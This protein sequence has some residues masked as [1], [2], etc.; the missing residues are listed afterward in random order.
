L[1]PTTCA[2]GHCT[3]PRGETCSDAPLLVRPP[4]GVLGVSALLRGVNDDVDVGPG[5]FDIGMS[6]AD[7]VFRIEL[8]AGER[9]DASLD[10][11]ERGVHSIYL[12]RSCDASECLA[13]GIGYREFFW[14]SR[15]VRFPAELTYT[16]SSAETV[17][18]VV[19]MLAGEDVD[20][21]AWR[22]LTVTWSRGSS[23][24][25]SCGGAS[26]PCPIGTTCL[27]PDDCL[28]GRCGGE[29]AACVPACSCRGVDPWCD[30]CHVATC[31]DGLQNGDETAVDTG[32]YCLGAALDTC[33]RAW[34]LPEPWRAFD[35]S[36]GYPVRAAGDLAP[37]RDDFA[38]SCGAGG[39]DHAWLVPNLCGTRITVTGSDPASPI[40][41]AVT[42]AC[43]GP[44]VACA[45]GIG[46]ATL[47]VDTAET[48]S[49]LWVD[50]PA[51]Q[52]YQLV[53]AA[54]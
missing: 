36:W 19:D 3:P 16:A 10:T 17:F 14:S 51:A 2:S 37:S 24:A 43:G 27:V 41:I 31:A 45:S 34:P 12:L 22:M 38:P 18:L 20:P 30:G 44:E 35:V 23:T 49:I 29:P 8:N 33:R 9:I 26:G 15:F 52:V 6:G 48:A 40:S 21:E 25:G 4:G 1:S 11:L 54:R 7:R 28:I 39:R 46:S 13:G 5:C 53:L 42:T 32:G 47:T 50:S